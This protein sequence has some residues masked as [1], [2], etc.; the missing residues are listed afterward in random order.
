VD[1]L[2]LVKRWLE[3]KDRGRWL[4]VVDN[5]DDARPFG[6]LGD[7]G[8]WIPECAH[9]SILVTTRNKEA[10]SRLIQGKRL[11]EVGKMDDSESKLLLLEKLEADGLDPGELSILSSRLEHL[12]LALV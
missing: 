8:Q 7:L 10:G 12:P 5:A 2:P 11:I 3:S 6:L 4:M 9:G 1:V